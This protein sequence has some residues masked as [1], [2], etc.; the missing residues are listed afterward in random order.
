LNDL[1]FL[2][3]L[4]PCFPV[5]RCRESH[6]FSALDASSV[7]VEPDSAETDDVDKTGNN[8]MAIVDPHLL[9][10]TNLDG[11][12]K[13]RGDVTEE[14][15]KRWET[16]GCEEK[17]KQLYVMWQKHSDATKGKCEELR[18]GAGI[19]VGVDW[20]FASTSEKRKWKDMMCD[21]HYASGWSDSCLHGRP[22]SVHTTT[23]AAGIEQA[24]AARSEDEK[25]ATRAS[26]S[27][28]ARFK[29]LLPGRGGQ[30][31]GLPVIAIV[32][33]TT[34]RGFRWSRL[35]ESP[36]VK[37]LLASIERTLEAG[38]EYRVYV[39]FDAGDLFYD[40]DDRRADIARWFSKH[41]Q[42]PAARRNISIKFA[43]LRFLNVLRKPG[44][45]FNFLA[46]SAFADDADF[47]YRI[48]DDTVGLKSAL[49]PRQKSHVSSTKEPCIALTCHPYHPGRAQRCAKRANMT[50]GAPDFAP[51]LQPES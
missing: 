34:S 13:K 10:C 45:I 26:P 50:C 17:L 48:N 49:H 9:K 41:V 33:G 31:E 30:S 23:T 16:L 1:V 47:V 42:A 2:L 35:S 46:A 20:G 6:D 29:S 36:L 51:P 28:S 7:G 18:V 4:P 27:V 3:P 44:P 19:E 14:E 15:K 40:D 11:L 21:C 24:V 38:F 22:P 8:W 39:G 43:T 12:I 25:L 37:I 5:L 32:L